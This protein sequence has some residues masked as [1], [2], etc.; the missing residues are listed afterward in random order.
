MPEHTDTNE[1]VWKSPEFMKPWLSQMDQRERKRAEQFAFMGHLLPFSA[2]DSFTFLDLGAGTGA[3]ARGILSMYPRATAILADYSPQMMGEGARVM[4]PF[5]GRYRYVEFDM[6]TSDWPAA[7]PDALDAAVTSQCI[8][9]L[10]DERKRSLFR[11]ILQRLKPG[12]WYV[13][14]DPIKASDPEVEAAWQRV[15]DKL[16]PATP[17]KR[18]DPTPEEQTMH[19]N[20]VRYMIPLE[21]QLDFLRAAGFQAVDVYWKQLDY[22]VYAGRRP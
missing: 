1:A 6:R 13:N 19:A 11:E 3:A 10:A 16:D 9:H 18:Q 5:E 22:V 7:V 8:H 17:A 20:H 15:N 14:F 4:A 2:E 12:A 21:P